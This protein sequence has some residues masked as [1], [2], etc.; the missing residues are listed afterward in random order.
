MKARVAALLAFV[1][2]GSS[3]V[4]ADS[5]G[6]VQTNLVSDGSVAAK[7]IDPNLINP[8]GIAESGSSPFWVGD[9]HTGVSTLYNTAGVK[10]GL[11]V[12]IP[13]GG[14][15]GAP[16]GL[17]FN[18]SS[19]TGAFNSDLFLFATENGTLAG[20]RGA[21]GA[22][23]ETLFTSSTPNADYTGLALI[24]NQAYLADNVNNRIDV[25][26]GNTAML[27]GSFTD[28][29]VPAGYAPF[30][31]QNIGGKL[32][33]TYALTAGGGVGDGFVDIFD[34]VTHT[35]TRLISGGVLADPWGLA[36]APSTFGIFANDLL[37]GNFADGTI[38]AFDPNSG[39]KLGTLMTPG[40]LTISNDSLWALQF[41][42]GGNGGDKNTLYF[43]AGLTNEEHGLFGAITFVP[44]PTSMVLLGTGLAGVMMRRKRRV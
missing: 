13:P 35:F 8:W 32:Y 9:N 20:W 17:A 40:G 43:T 41:G 14:G 25:V 26:D 23:A 6:Y 1:F 34:P 27:T 3:L 21:L 4:L 28:P 15:K 2:L 5:S 42:N 38:N 10:Q 12:T 22:A 24:G 7:T 39:A 11:T 44:E 37:V 29:S 19:G 31:I 36:L 18:A 16:S 33:V 30:N